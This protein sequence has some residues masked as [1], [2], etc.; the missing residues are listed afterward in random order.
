MTTTL[1]YGQYTPTGMKS[2]HYT[3]RDV[4]GKMVRWKSLEGTSSLNGRKIYGQRRVGNPRSNILL[5]SN[6]CHCARIICSKGCSTK[7]YECPDCI[8]RYCR[9]SVI[10]RTISVGRYYTALPLNIPMVSSRPRER[11]TVLR[12]VSPWT[13]LW[14]LSMARNLETVLGH[15]GGWSKWACMDMAA[16]N[17]HPTR[18]YYSRPHTQDGYITEKD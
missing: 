5:Q 15:A 12:L 6:T 16:S 4:A 13:I 10:W 18:G 9:I 1:H 8:H 3:C 14:N 17:N 7:A 2:N 11:G